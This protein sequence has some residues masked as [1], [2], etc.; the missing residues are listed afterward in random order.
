MEGLSLED[1][2]GCVDDFRCQ[3]RFGSLFSKLESDQYQN[4][5]RRNHAQTDYPG[6]TVRKVVNRARNLHPTPG[7]RAGNRHRPALA[8]AATLV[9]IVSHRSPLTARGRS[10]IGR[11]GGAAGPDTR[12]GEVG[13]A[14][15]SSRSRDKAD[16]SAPP[17]T[18]RAPRG[19]RRRTALL[20]DDDA[21][22]SPP[23]RAL[24]ADARSLAHGLSGLLP[25]AANSPF[26]GWTILWGKRGDCLP[27]ILLC[28]GR[29]PTALQNT[30]KN[31]LPTRPRKPSVSHRG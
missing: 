24:P 4:P 22:P 9:T 3:S 1:T 27:S 10:L 12:R 13:N 21:L 31:Q 11:V 8:L 30:N 5:L 2:S 16:G 15:A 6:S 25:R 20:V 14:Q 23:R 18:R 17:A 29:V 7:H 28:G 26:T 19:C